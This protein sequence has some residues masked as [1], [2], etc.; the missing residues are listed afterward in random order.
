MIELLRE[1]RSVR[2]YEPRPIEREKIEILKEALLRS[3]S[4]RGLSPWFFVF[5]E[6]RKLLQSL[7][8]AKPHGSDFLKEAALAVVVCAD[9]GVSD[10]WIE[11][12][13]IASIILQLSAHSIGLG[14]CWIQIRGRSHSAQ[15]SAE[16][17]VREVLGIPEPLRVL[18]IISIGYPAEKKG[19]TP[20]EMLHH[21]KVYLNHFGSPW[22]S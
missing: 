13:A 1:R 3:P 9:E 5:V 19:P 11:D 14:S 7:S 16:Q 22:S 15:K 18:C 17:Y 2:R 4:S 8:L 6:D 12:G 20:Y 21:S 10:C